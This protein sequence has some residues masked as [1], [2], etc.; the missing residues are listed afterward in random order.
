MLILNKATSVSAEGAYNDA[1]DEFHYGQA[2][3]G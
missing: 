3:L 1:P 2:K